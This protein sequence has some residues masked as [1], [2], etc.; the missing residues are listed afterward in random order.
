LAAK[1][2]QAK[3]NKIAWICL[4]LFVRTETFQW[5]TAN[6]NKKIFSRLNLDA[7]RLKPAFPLI[8]S[9]ARGAGQGA[10]FGLAHGKTYR[11]W[12]GK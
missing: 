8:L 10:G 5:V 2:K 7:K 12:L 9:L 11:F 6:P 1:Q 3:P 4:G